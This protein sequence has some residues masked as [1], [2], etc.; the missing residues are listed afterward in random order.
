[1][2]EMDRDSYKTAFN[3]STHS[4]GKDHYESGT[5]DVVREVE[6]YLYSIFNTARIQTS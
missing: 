3:T 1:M 4:E 2:I 6:S 5:Q